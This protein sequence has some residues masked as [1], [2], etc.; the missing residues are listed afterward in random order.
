M[1]LPLRPFLL[2]LPCVAL[3]CAPLAAQTGP[4]LSMN[5]VTFSVTGGTDQ[6]VNALDGGAEVVLDGRTIQM[7]GTTV[8]VDG[9]AYDAGPFDRIDIDATTGRL[10]VTADGN[11]VMQETQAGALARAG[12]DHQPRALS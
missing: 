11:L 1:A 8:T 3:L 2:A 4:A 7:V 5:G 6:A 12:P 9:T 10:I